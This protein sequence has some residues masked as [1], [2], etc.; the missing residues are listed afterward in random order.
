MINPNFWYKLLFEDLTKLW[1]HRPD[2]HGLFLQQ[3][4]QMTKRTPGGQFASSMQLADKS[5]GEKD[6]RRQKL[7]EEL[8]RTKEGIETGNRGSL[9]GH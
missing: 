2:K 5:V 6:K 1:E 3:R 9:G 7:K 8:I 4:A